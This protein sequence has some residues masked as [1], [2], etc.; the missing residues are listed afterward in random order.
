MGIGDEIMATA[1]ARKLKQLNPSAKIIV[2][3]GQREYWSPVF[4]NNPNISRL[5][6]LRQ[7]DEIIWLKNYRGHRPYIDYAKSDMDY[8]MRYLDYQVEPGDIFVSSEVDLYGRSSLDT[9]GIKEG[10]YVFIEPNVEFG[11][12]KDWGLGRWQQVVDALAGEVEF[13]QPVYNQVRRLSGVGLV[14]TENFLYACG[15]LA[16]SAMY[17]GPEGGLHH[18]SAALGIPGVVIFGGR[19]H[20]R[21]TGYTFHT[22]LYVDDPESPCGMIVACDHCRR[23]FEQITVDRVVEAIQTHLSLGR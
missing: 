19:I 3:D 12:P 18:A 22:N 13:I 17:A 2:G 16:L 4:E 7:D 1:E 8:R 15:I 9:L 11:Q 21:T 5:A 6:Q 23:C 14:H 20:P 10:G